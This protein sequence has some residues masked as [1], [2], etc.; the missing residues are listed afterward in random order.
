MTNN[1]WKDRID[2]KTGKRYK[3]TALVLH[4]TEGSSRSALRWFSDPHSYA[5]SNYLVDEDGNWITVVPE[6]HAAWANGYIFRPKWDGLVKNVN[7]NL[8]TISV[9]A[10]SLGGFPSW[11]QWTSWAKGCK[12]I[13][14]RH[15]W[16]VDSVHVVNHN[17]IRSN[18]VCPGRWFNRFYLGL[19]VRMLKL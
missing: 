18:K 3:P 6:Q 17:E 2:P 7:P 8:Y 10:A 1:Y 14:D 16:T 13:C 11:K 4:I 5:S 9:E 19:L 12:G 15:G